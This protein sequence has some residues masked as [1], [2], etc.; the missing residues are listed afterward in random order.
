MARRWVI[1]RW[2]VISWRGVV[3]RWRIVTGRWITTWWRIVTRWR[4]VANRRLIARRLSSSRRLWPFMPFRSFRLRRWLAS[5]RS[6]GRAQR[7]FRFADLRFGGDDWPGNSFLG[8]RG[9]LSRDSIYI[10]V[11]AWLDAW[12]I[13]TNRARRPRNRACRTR[14]H[15]PTGAR[16]WSRHFRTS[17]G[18]LASVQNSRPAQFIVEFRAG[19]TSGRTCLSI[20]RI[21]GRRN[22]SWVNDRHALSATVRGGPLTRSA[23]GVRRSDR[24]VSAQ[25]FRVER[26]LGQRFVSA[27]QPR[28]AGAKIRCRQRRHRAVV[29]GIHSLQPRELVGMQRTRAIVL[30][31]VTRMRIALVI[32][33]RI[34]ADVVAERNGKRDERR[35][36]PTAMPVITAARTPGPIVVV[37]DPAAVVIRRPAPRLVANPGPAVRRNP[38]PAA[39]TIGRPVI[40]VVDDRRVRTPDPTIVSRVSPVAVGIKV[41]GA[42]NVLVVILRRS[43]AA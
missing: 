8:A 2:R 28:A 41:F 17:E 29:G 40:V 21:S 18:A 4:I 13:F 16:G 3:T 37:I 7:P 10:G 38:T 31:V 9:T 23:R 14:F 24:Q 20:V 33:Q 27:S 5:L 25:R 34:P 36:P 39:V 42:P 32:V 43:E 26:A 35:P 6:L 30:V 15:W 22:S 12:L 19:R 1:A 11:V